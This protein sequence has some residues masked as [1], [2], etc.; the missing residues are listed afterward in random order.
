MLLQ[1]IEV[2]VLLFVDDGRF[3]VKEF[4][5]VGGAVEDVVVVASAAVLYI[6]VHLET[7]KIINL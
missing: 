2:V 7:N 6:G 3:G 5:I 1:E 4:E